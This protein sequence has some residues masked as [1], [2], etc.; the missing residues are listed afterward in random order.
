MFDRKKPCSNCPFRI[1]RGSLFN[2]HAERLEEIREG[3][4]FQCHK[5]IDYDEFDDELLRQGSN[6]QQ[7]AGLMSVLFAEDC[8]NTIMR[9]ALHFKVLDPASL[10]TSTAYKSWQDVLSAHLDGCEPMSQPSPSSHHP[11][12]T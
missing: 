10:D 1:G 3:P 6:P 5:T 2:L 9:A 7:C 8:P 4:A 12:E 11:K